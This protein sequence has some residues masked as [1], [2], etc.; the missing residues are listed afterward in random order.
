MAPV[1]PWHLCLQL[2]AE[3][4]VGAQYLFTIVDADQDYEAAGR[5]G[6]REDKDSSLCLSE[7]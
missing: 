1:A 3:Q 5:G 4:T 6:R 2:R 7:Q